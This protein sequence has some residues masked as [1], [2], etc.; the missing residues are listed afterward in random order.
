MKV[1]NPSLLT[2]KRPQPTSLPRTVSSTCFNCI[3][4]KQGLCSAFFVSSLLEICFS[5]GVGTTCSTR[6]FKVITV[7]T[8]HVWQAAG[9]GQASRKKGQGPSNKSPL[10]KLQV[11]TSCSLT[12]SSPQKRQGSDLHTAEVQGC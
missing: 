2:A 8:W 10:K 11:E 5:K 3:Q 6:N 9:Q 7:G 4:Q 12:P 1:I